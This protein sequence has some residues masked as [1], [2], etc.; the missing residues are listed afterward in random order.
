MRKTCVMLLLLISAAG[1]GQFV[2]IIGGGGASTAAIN[3]VIEANEDT[4]NY[5]SNVT[6]DATGDTTLTYYN[7]N[8]G[9]KP[10]TP[11]IGYVIAG[12]EAT[13]NP[14]DGSTFAFGGSPELTLQTTFG[15]VKRIPIVK[16]G[17]IKVVTVYWL[18][19]GAAGST[20]DVV[21]YVRLNNTTD[22]EIATVHNTSATKTITNSALSIAV[23]AGDYIELKM[24]CPTWATNPTSVVLNY[25]IYIE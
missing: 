10:A 25:A 6:E 8:I 14:T 13:F 5:I 18:S 7:G 24:I 16:A 21:M 9:F 15:A 17:T 3:I 1:Y 12:N 22:S 23:A 4:T 19:Y 11:S 2:N 20:E